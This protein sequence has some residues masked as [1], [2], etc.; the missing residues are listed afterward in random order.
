MFAHPV[1]ELRPLKK[2]KE[3][4]QK[5]IKKTTTVSNHTHAVVTH[6]SNNTKQQTVELKR[7][8]RPRRTH[9]IGHCLGRITFRLETAAIR[10]LC[11]TPKKMDVN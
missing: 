3:I 9:I 11:A 5:I 10:P 7:E 6:N 1:V 2:W 8:N 4:F